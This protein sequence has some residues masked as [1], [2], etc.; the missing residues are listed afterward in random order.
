MKTSAVVSLILISAASGAALHWKLAHGSSDSHQEHAPHDDH[1]EKPPEVSSQALLNMGVE[2]VDAEVVSY[3][4]TLG[5][6][7]ILEE[8]PLA[9]QAVYAHIGGHIL[10]VDVAPGMRVRKGQRLATLMR[11]AI[12]R[13]ELSIVMGHLQASKSVLMIDAVELQEWAGSAQTGPEAQQAARSAEALRAKLA[14]RGLASEEITAIEKGEAP[15]AFAVAVWKKTLERGGLWNALA[16]RIFNSLPEESKKTPWSVA[17]VGELLAEGLVSIALAD[18]LAKEPTAAVHLMEV[19]SLLQ[20]GNSLEHV[21]HLHELGFFDP[22]VEICA[23]GE[24]ET[25]EWDVREIHVVP[26]TNVVL[27]SP[28]FT[29]VDARRMV[30]NVELTP[31]ETAMAEEAL[32]KEWNLE[33]Y[34]LAREGGLVL[35]GLRLGRLAGSGPGRNR[36]YA[37]VRNEALVLPAGDQALFHNWRLREGQQ[38]SLRLPLRRWGEVIVVPSDAVVEEGADLVVLMRNGKVFESRK[39]VVLHRDHEVAV[40]DPNSSDLF[41]GDPIVVK[42]AFALGLA[43]KASKSGGVDAHAGHVH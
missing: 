4:L 2:V 13:P 38:Y 43:I 7:A 31:T 21:Q 30:L 11:E 41:P 39:V 17:V 27:D 34:P 22:V 6:K 42:G 14:L 20:Q 28:L 35:R 25:P 33:A 9:R 32:V 36:A 24:G 18:W 40:L 19:A 16:E 8:P 29:L 10:S 1:D 23:S 26:G 15:P 3:D 5:I 12:A 37:E